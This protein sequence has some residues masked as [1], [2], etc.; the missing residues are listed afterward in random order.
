MCAYYILHL[1]DDRVDT[2]RHIYSLLKPGG[3]FVQSTVVLG[4]SWVP[5]GPMLT[6]MRWFG[7][8]PRVDIFDRQTLLSDMH[9][10]GFVD[11]ST[12]DVGASKDTAFVVAR[13]P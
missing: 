3:F 4:G 13:K 2:L 9:E 1:V 10:L 5:F 6:V 12:P 11:I 8:A 7:K